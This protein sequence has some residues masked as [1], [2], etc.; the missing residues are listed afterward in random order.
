MHWTAKRHNYAPRSRGLQSQHAGIRRE[1]GRAG[2]LRNHD[3]RASRTPGRDHGYD[4]RRHGAGRT[5]RRLLPKPALAGQAGDGYPDG[6]EEFRRCEGAD[7][8][9]DGKA[10]DSVTL[11][12]A[13]ALDRRND[14]SVYWNSSKYNSV[15]SRKLAIAS[16]TVSPWLTVPTSEHSAT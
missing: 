14:S 5:T 6:D 8:E 13:G 16:P 3:G 9:R 15:A 2:T 1:T 4:Y 10:E 12:G 7:P 11:C